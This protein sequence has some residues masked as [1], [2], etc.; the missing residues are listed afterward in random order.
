V[1]LSDK[2]AFM[3]SIPPNSHFA[4][5]WRQPRLMDRFY[6]LPSGSFLFGSLDFQSPFSSLAFAETEEGKWNFKRTG[7]WQQKVTIPNANNSQEIAIY[8]PRFWGGKSEI[9]F[10][11]GRIYV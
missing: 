4:A 2:V 7:F 8:R 9:Q 10:S 1:R 6:E 5:E 11:N 3:H